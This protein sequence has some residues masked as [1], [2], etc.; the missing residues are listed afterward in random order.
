MAQD[1]E[2]T[3]VLQVHIPGD[4]EFQTVLASS[5]PAPEHDA[6]VDST[7]RELILTRGGEIQMPANEA[8]YGEDPP[9]AWQD[10]PDDPLR[11]TIIP[12]EGVAIAYYL[13]LLE[14][15]EF[16]EEDAFETIEELVDMEPYYSFQD[17][18]DEQSRKLRLIDLLEWRAENGDKIAEPY[19]KEKPCRWRSTNLSGES[20]DIAERIVYSIDVEPA[21]CYL[22]ARRAALLHKDNHR[23][24]PRIQYVEGYALPESGAQA[25]RHAWIEIDGEVVET[26]WPWHDLD[27]GDAVYFG[28][29]LDMEDVVER[30]NQD[31][32]GPIAPSDDVVEQLLATSGSSRGF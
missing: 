7:E 30:E 8:G 12:D 25:I 23:L 31:I 21:S 9:F 32:G 28:Y 15:H 18:L 22:T 19:L 3:E 27:G 11:R 20:R 26:T 16:D 5:A 24:A 4:E 14:I 1:Q 13:H 29:A 6:M 2:E 17:S 10:P